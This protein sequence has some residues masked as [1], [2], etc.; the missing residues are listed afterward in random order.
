MHLFSAG[1]EMGGGGDDQQAA[2]GDGLNL[3]V[4]NVPVLSLIKVANTTYKLHEA[5]SK[6]AVSRFFKIGDFFI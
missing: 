3:G 4:H 6:T 2:V 1:E 5:V